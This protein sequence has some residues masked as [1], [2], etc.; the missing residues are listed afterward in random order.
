MA[1][2][3]TSTFTAGA[4]RSS[5][6]KRAVS[7]VAAD[8]SPAR[9]RT[10]QTPATRQI[11]ASER[12]A[13]A[14]DQLASGLT[15]ASAA[16]EEL[17]RAMEQIATGGEEA[18]G[19]SQEQLGAIKNISVNL[20]TARDQAEVCRRRT[21]VVRS[22]LTDTSTQITASIRVIER[23]AARQQAS[24]EM[25]ALLERS[26]QEIGEIT[27]T[28]SD[29]SDRTN[30][31]A[32]NAAIE[33]ARA[34]D[35]GRG[36]AVVAEEVRSLAEKSESRALDVQR[37]VE[38]IQA[39]IRDAAQSVRAA[40]ETAVGE[41]ATGTA[42]VQRL[43]AMR[44]EIERL[45]DGS[46]DTVTTAVQAVG[47]VGDVQ[48]GAEQVAAAAQDQSAAAAE[49]QA[50][51]QQQAQALDQGQRAAQTL[52]ALTDGLRAG[53]AG[54]S[55][56]EQ[57]GTM[58]EELSATIQEL[59]SAAAE[60]MTAVTQINS[61][62]QQQAAAT[63]E[64]FAALSQIE[65]SA[66]LAQEN[67]E[68]AIA[69][70]QELSRT[71]DDSRATAQ[72]LVAGV[73]QGSRDAGASLEQVVALEITSRQIDK[74]ADGIALI[75]IKTGMLAVS[76]AVEAARAGD[77]GRGFALVSG[78]IG[79]LAGEAEERADRI[80]DTVRAMM[81]RI[82]SV[83]RDLEQTINL[84]DAEL[85]KSSTIAEAFLAVDTEMA[86]M[87]AANAAVL[88]GTKAMQSD[89]AAS[90]AGA[91]Q[92]ATAAEEASAASTQAASASAQQ[93]KGAEDLA[94]AIEE[95]AS[96]ADELKPSNG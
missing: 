94:A 47:A 29:I 13:A 93:A 45:N 56:A 67:A 38:T 96:L 25:I 23:N 17:R 40:A 28:V 26:A 1:L 5:A 87:S 58:A 31:F 39:S 22:L 89:L 68:L 55:A 59:S 85:G 12:V 57:I 71:V 54:A 46:V 44:E 61:R 66:G 43:D 33:A 11:Q 30:L 32:L 20:A 7:P 80:K 72:R 6:A 48:K 69:R 84:I 41:A 36:F 50:A 51:I 8:N 78:D 49:A 70:L 10:R 77:A 35:H 95:I 86:A 65:R 18:A 79:V 37:I 62:A 9:A 91:R 60:I 74:I 81:D 90:A 53:S 21:E 24:V 88:D 14:T 92:I 82:V 75:A 3:K 76:G 2:V 52:A 4:T 64:S 15:E 27:L 83:R 16:A 63:V 34:G 19:A 42:L 73:A